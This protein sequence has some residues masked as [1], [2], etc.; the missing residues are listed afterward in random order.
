MSRSAFRC[1]LATVPTVLLFVYGSLKRG[2]RNH[3]VLEG[4]E[5]V[6]EASTEAGYRLV[7]Y[8][9]YPALAQERGSDERVFGEL[10]RV[11]AA[12]LPRLDEFE[13]VP[14]LY[15]RAEVILDD[16]CRAQSYVISP[17][18]AKLYAPVPFGTWQSHW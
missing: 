13:D 12:D 11:D 15:Q 8:G 10:Y 1:T 3:S 17:E 5:L 4:A 7:C 18:V 2:F 9:E 14:R 16:G 6:R